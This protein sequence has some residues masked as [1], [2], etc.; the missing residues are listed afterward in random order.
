[1]RIKIYG[2]QSH[3]YM[4]GDYFRLYWNNGSGAVDLVNPVIDRVAVWPGQTLGPVADEQSES[5]TPTDSREENTFTVDNAIAD[6]GLG[7]QP[8]GMIEIF[9][10]NLEAGLYKFALAAVDMFDNILG[11]GL[12]KYFNVWV[13]EVPQAP[14]NFKVDTFDK[15]NDRLSFTFTPSRSLS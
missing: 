7:D 9:N 10:R 14:R 12:W 6:A 3:D 2:Y 8:A 5:R 11:S 13:C 4:P 15:V 1:M